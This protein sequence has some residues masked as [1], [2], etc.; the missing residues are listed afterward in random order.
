M[1]ITQYSSK[2][3]TLDDKINDLRT[4]KDQL[5]YTLHK[6]KTTITAEVD[7][8]K[9]KSNQIRENYIAL[10]IVQ[11]T[12]CDKIYI[13]LLKVQKDLRE[14]S[15]DHAQIRREYRILENEYLAHGIRKFE[16]IKRESTS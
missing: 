8:E 2:L 9:Y 7:K 13:R 6:K 15:A 4:E 11:N 12:E 3:K 5:E 14:L 16:D 1:D 10:A